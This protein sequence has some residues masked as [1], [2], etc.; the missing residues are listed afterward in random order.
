MIRLCDMILSPR[1]IQ[2]SQTRRM[3]HLAFYSTHHRTRQDQ[4]PEQDHCTGKYL[5]S[6]NQLRHIYSRV[7]ILTV[8]RTRKKR[9]PNSRPIWHVLIANTPRGKVN[10]HQPILNGN[11]RVYAIE[12]SAKKSQL[13]P[14]PQRINA[15]RNPRAEKMSPA[16][17]GRV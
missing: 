4:N 6:Y 11:L 10:P 12:V 7:K 2:I 8:P 13:S 17:A 3:K 16:L 5:F 1:N 14:K 9:D 15:V